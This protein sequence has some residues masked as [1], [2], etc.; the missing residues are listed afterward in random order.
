MCWH[1]VSTGILNRP[2]K[3]YKRMITQTSYKRLAHKPTVRQIIVNDDN[4]PNKTHIFRK[5]KD[6]HYAYNQGINGLPFYARFERLTRSHGYYHY[7]EKS[8]LN[9]NHAIFKD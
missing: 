9:F 2:T 5:Y 8:I 4:N 3:G 6:G 7:L 1:T